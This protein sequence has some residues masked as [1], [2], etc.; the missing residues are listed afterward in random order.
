MKAWQVILDLG[1]AW[2]GIES[3]IGLLREMLKLRGKAKGKEWQT[4]GKYSKD[5]NPSKE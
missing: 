4:L 5:R 2:V 3:S 1:L